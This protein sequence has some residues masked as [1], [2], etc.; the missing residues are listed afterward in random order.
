MDAGRLFMF[1]L[2]FQVYTVFLAVL[3]IGVLVEWI[4]C[5]WLHSNITSKKIKMHQYF[6]HIFV[7]DTKHS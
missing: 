1:M 4:G 2:P 5:G 7:Y 6:A 3:L